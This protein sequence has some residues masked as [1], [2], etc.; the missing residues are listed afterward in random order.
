VTDPEERSEDAFYVRAVWHHH[1]KVSQVFDNWSTIILERDSGSHFQNNIAFF[2]STIGSD[3]GKKFIVSGMDS[4]NVMGL[5][6][7]LLALCDQS[8]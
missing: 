2:E 1:L 3:Y 7:G 4:M 8:H 6:H 5:W